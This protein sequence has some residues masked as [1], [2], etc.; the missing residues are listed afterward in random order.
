MLRSAAFQF[1]FIIVAAFLASANPAIAGASSPPNLAPELTF[2][3]VDPVSGERQECGEDCRRFDVPAGVDLEI[4]VQVVNLGDN[5]NTDGVDWDLWFDQPRSPFPP[6]DFAACIDSEQRLDTDCYYGMMDRVDWD[7][8]HIQDA[9]RVCLPDDPSDCYDETV[10]IPMDADF[11]GSR[12]R[13]VYTFM[14]WVDRF[15]TKIETDDFD[16]VAGP[17]RVKVLPRAAIEP[18]KPVGPLVVIDPGKKVVAPATVGASSQK[19]VFAPTSPRS[20]TFRVSRAQDEKS[21]D[22]SSRVAR[23]N[24][25]FVVSYP[26]VVAVEVEQD[27]VWDGMIVEVRKVSTGEILVEGSGKGRMRLEV[28]IEKVHLIDDRQFEVVVRHGQGTWGL[29]GTIRVRYPD[30]G[31]YI[32]N[33]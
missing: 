33:Q 19:T 26:G 27:G 18:V 5:P 20:F 2:S 16:N 30:R 23:A 25:A 13:G 11:D 17:V 24:L 4:R 12:G 6:E 29:R 7:W 14:V 3:Y 15:D 10:S 9:D 32:R 1:S 31:V 22:L 28:G 8:W 21:F